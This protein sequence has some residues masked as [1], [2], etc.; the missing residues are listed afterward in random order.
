MLSNSHNIEY[1]V[2]RNRHYEETLKKC[3][4][5]LPL[6]Y[7]SEKQSDNQKTKSGKGKII[8]FKFFIQF[9]C[10]KQRSKNLLEINRQK[11]PHNFS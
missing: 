9:Y 4:Y 8:W 7:I 10:F 2:V 11:L 5:A 6:K 1:F 3:E